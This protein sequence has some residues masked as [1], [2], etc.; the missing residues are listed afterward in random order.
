MNHGSIF[1]E[2]WVLPLEILQQECAQQPPPKQ[3]F[4]M[5]QQNSD[6]NKLLQSQATEAKY[7]V[8]HTWAATQMQFPFCYI[9]QSS[10]TGSRTLPESRVCQS[11]DQHCLPFPTQNTDSARRPLKHKGTGSHDTPLEYSSIA[12]S[13]Q[14]LIL[15]HHLW[16]TMPSR[17]QL[18][19]HVWVENRCHL[20]ASLPPVQCGAFISPCFSLAQAPF[21]HCQAISGILLHLELFFSS[22][23]LSF[24]CWAHSH[25]SVHVYRG[26]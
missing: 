22:E 10:T 11:P 17:R 26:L 16:L 8:F 19:T 21:P 14:G 1:P 20:P 2:A 18:E 5:I 23:L 12:P 13:V 3:Q 6:R 7:C 15:V 25:D 4:V 9:S 24:F